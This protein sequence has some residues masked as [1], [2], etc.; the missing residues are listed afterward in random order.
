MLD[1][2]RYNGTIS[3]TRRS[4]TH[5]LRITTEE[6]KN[7]VKR[8]IRRVIVSETSGKE[9][10]SAPIGFVT[11]DGEIVETAAFPKQKALISLLQK[12]EQYAQRGFSFTMDRRCRRCGAP[13]SDP[14]S[15]A[16]GLGPVCRKK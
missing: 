9:F 2:A 5:R 14:Q 7:E 1:L 15:V 10:I 16:T 11:P 6:R 13:L 8:I 12:R 4:D 3:I